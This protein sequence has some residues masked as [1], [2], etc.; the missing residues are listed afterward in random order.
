MIINYVANIAIMYFTYQGVYFVV[1]LLFAYIGKELYHFTFTIFMRNY[2]YK[3]Q[4]IIFNFTAK[5]DC[6][7]GRNNVKEPLSDAFLIKVQSCTATIIA[8]NWL[9]SAAHCFSEDVLNSGLSNITEYGDSELDLREL[10]FTADYYVI[11]KRYL[12]FDKF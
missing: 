12:L 8:D 3:E 6:S 7:I 10:Y 2:C 9:L 5:L 1:L 11:T 4:I